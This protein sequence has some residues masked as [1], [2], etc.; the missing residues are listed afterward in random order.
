M[1]MRLP[2]QLDLVLTCHYDRDRFQL[3]CVVAAP[4]SLLAIAASRSLLAKHRKPDSGK[5]SSV[6]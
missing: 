1:Q 2:I 3:Y 5:I 4:Q 6:K